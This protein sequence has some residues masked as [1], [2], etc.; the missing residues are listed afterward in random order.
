L[1]VSLVRQLFHWPYLRQYFQPRPGARQL[2][3]AWQLPIAAARLADGIVEE[4][5]QLLAHI[6][7]LISA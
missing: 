6:A 4:R 1:L 7:G 2:L 3:D 5:S